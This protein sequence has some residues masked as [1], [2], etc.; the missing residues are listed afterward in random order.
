M[1]RAAGHEVAVALGPAEALRQAAPG[2]AQL[3]MID[4]R[5]L[6]AAGE[7]DRRAGLAPT[8]RLREQSARVPLVVLSGWPDDLY[9]KPVPTREL[10]EAIEQLV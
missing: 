9:G 7:P 8:R 1:R 3:I 2:W 4:L 10:L 5:F 6:N